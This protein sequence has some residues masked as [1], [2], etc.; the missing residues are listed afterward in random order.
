MIIDILH[1]YGIAVIFDVVYNHAGGDFGNESL[2]FFDRA[3]RGNNNDSLY[4][5]D[6]GWAG[7]LAFAYWNAS[8]RQF[9]IDNAVAMMHDFH[10][11]GF[12]Y[13][14]VSVIDRFGGWYFCQ[15]LTS[16]VRT[17]KPSAVQIA[18]F[19][20]PGPDSVVRP[21]SSGGAGFDMV[22]S[23]RMRD[24]VRSVLEQAAHGAFAD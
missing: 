18:A 4:F 13:D 3:G 5:T 17:A 20:N 22:W 23:D 7:S 10:V 11:D 24:G 9:L 16:T 6:R 8:V 12:Q 15:D 14:E 21:S 1:V 19:W 2:Y